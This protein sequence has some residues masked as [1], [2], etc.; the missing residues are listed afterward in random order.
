MFI[1]F[2]NVSKTNIIKKCKELNIRYA[3][4]LL[5]KLKINNDNDINN[6][7]VSS[8]INDGLIDLSDKT[9][10]FALFTFTSSKVDFKKLFMG[11]YLEQYYKESDAENL[12]LV[13]EWLGVVFGVG[14]KYPS[15][16]ILDTIEK[17]YKV[18]DLTE[19]MDYEIFPFISSVYSELYELSVVEGKSPEEVITKIDGKKIKNLP[20]TNAKK[21]SQREVLTRICGDLTQEQLASRLGKTQATVNRYFSSTA[22]QSTS[23]VYKRDLVKD[24]CIASHTTK[25]IANWAFKQFRC[26]EIDFEKDKDW[27]PKLRSETLTD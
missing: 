15:L 27:L 14:G 12:D 3:G 25:S 13:M 23:L 1:N 11:N 10:Q 7:V 2:V 4:I 9:G 17:K 19:K 8:I 26:E 21:Y 5:Y 16:V 22:K 18:F 24:I 6:R 20:N